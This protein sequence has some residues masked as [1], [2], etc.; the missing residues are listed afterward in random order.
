MDAKYSFIKLLWLAYSVL[1]DAG[2][3]G[4][5]NA[6]GAGG[7]GF[8]LVGFSGPELLVVKCGL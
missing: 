3:S 6:I 8:R 5:L 2:G 7:V 4:A 1:A